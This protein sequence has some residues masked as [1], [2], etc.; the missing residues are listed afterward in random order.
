MPTLGIRGAFVRKYDCNGGQ[1]WVRQIGVEVG[2]FGTGLVA[3]SGRVTAVGYVGGALPGQ[4]FAGQRDAFVRTYNSSG[5]E[6]WTRQFGT[7]ESDFAVGVSAAPGAVYV[8]GGTNGVFPG[9]T[10]AGF[11]D[12]FIRKYDGAGVEL[13][14]TQFGSS[15]Y[16]SGWGISFTPGGVY[17]VGETP[18]ALPGQNSA[19]GVD[20]FLAILSAQ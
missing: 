14:T 2:G 6:L 20:A 12:V 7:T 17:V 16:D 15:D 3:F 13:W 10:N 11:E 8:L 18:G 4:T 5:T 1:R 9:Q 19:G